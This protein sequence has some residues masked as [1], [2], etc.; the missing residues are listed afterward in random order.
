MPFHSPKD[1]AFAHGCHN[2]TQNHKKKIPVWQL[3]HQDVCASVS[4]GASPYDL[5][6]AGLSCINC[7]RRIWTDVSSRSQLWACLRSA[8]MLDTDSQLPC[9]CVD[10]R[11]RGTGKKMVPS[12]ARGVLE[13]S[14]GTYSGG[15]M[16]KR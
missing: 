12:A 10:R 3:N 8:C 2:F 1:P 9:V 11:W 15:F 6:E 14:S 5:L 7:P 4:P 13:S 16:M